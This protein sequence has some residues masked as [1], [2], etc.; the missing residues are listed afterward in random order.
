MRGEE[1]ESLQNLYRFASMVFVHRQDRQGREPSG[2]CGILSLL[3]FAF[4][5][6]I[7]GRRLNDFCQ[8]QRSHLISCQY[9]LMFPNREHDNLL[10]FHAA[11]CF[12]FSGFTP[13][14]CFKFVRHT[15][16]R[17]RERKRERKCGWRKSRVTNYILHITISPAAATQRLFISGFHFWLALI[18]AERLR[19]H[20]SRRPPRG[21]SRGEKIIKYYYDKF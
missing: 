7:H 16:N 11:R 5:P 21:S 12:Y 15:K 1:E 8:C 18:K 9:S 4:R 2:A 17:G 10:R 19:F 14:R 13:P 6:L 3:S 20:S